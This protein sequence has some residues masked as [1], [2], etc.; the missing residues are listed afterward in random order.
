MRLYGFLDGRYLVHHFLI[1][2]QTTGGIDDDDVFALS[3][4]VLD[5]ILRNLHR[6]LVAFLAIDFNLNLLTQHLQL[7]D[8]C[9]TIHVASHQQHLLAAL[10]LQVGG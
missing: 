1:N 7:L 8:S 4:G 9:G 5:S 3:L 2:G 6:I 10:A